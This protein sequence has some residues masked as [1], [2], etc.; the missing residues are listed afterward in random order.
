MPCVSFLGDVNIDHRVMD[1]RV[2]HPA[3]DTATCRFPPPSPKSRG[4]VEAPKPRM[5]RVARRRYKRPDQGRG[6]ARHD[7]AYRALADLEWEVVEAR[8]AH[9]R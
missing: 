6:A 9:V 2:S 7:T 1:I 3:G 5:W 8:L 4:R